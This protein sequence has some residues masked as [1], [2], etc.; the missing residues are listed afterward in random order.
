MRIEFINSKEF[1][2][3]RRRSILITRVWSVLKRGKLFQSYI[4]KY[5]ESK[6]RK[7]G[8][9]KTTSHN[10]NGERV[11]THTYNVCSQV[12]NNLIEIFEMSQ[13]KRLR[14]NLYH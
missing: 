9:I 12:Q 8:F 13:S 4:C 10:I 5:I 6:T 1:Y 11:K 7:K 14:K 2:E 3:L